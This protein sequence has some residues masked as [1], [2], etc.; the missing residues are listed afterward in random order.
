MF[1]NRCQKLLFGLRRNEV[2][3]GWRTLH[4]EKLHNLYTL[5]SII[6]MMKLR[7]VGWAVHV[8]QIGRRGMHVG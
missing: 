6:K 3:A 1:E 2:T 8:A 5:P 7:M 4:N